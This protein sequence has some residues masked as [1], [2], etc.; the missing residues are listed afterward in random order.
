MDL[1]SYV[2]SDL[3]AQKNCIILVDYNV[4]NGKEYNVYT[5]KK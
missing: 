4:A 3:K 2:W 1:K 5:S